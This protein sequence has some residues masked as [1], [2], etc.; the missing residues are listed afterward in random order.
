MAPGTGAFS[1]RR[2]STSAMVNHIKPKMTTLPMSLK[3]FSILDRAR[4]TDNRSP[5]PRCWSFLRRQHRRFVSLA[6]G[7]LSAQFSG[8]EPTSCSHPARALDLVI[9]S[10]GWSQ[11]SIRSI[12]GCTVVLHAPGGDHPVDGLISQGDQIAGEVADKD[13][14]PRSSEPP[15]PPATKLPRC[16]TLIAWAGRSDFYRGLIRGPRKRCLFHSS[17]AV[18]NR[19]TCIRS[20]R[21]YL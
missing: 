20:T 21:D 1:K 11:K 8:P 18:G 19:A 10:T 3:M 6:P 5:R 9:V 4:S 15:K 17:E 16:G 7:F 12:R 13:V 14:Q 2:P